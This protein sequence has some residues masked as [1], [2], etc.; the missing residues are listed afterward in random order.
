MI[1]RGKHHALLLL[2]PI[3]KTVMDNCRIESNVRAWLKEPPGA[4]HYGQARL[5]WSLR[6]LRSPLRIDPVMEAVCIAHDGNPDSR[7]DR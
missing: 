2:V 3:Y 5:G 6:W 1:G 4:F 7:D